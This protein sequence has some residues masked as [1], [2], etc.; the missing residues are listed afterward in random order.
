MASAQAAGLVDDASMRIADLARVPTERRADFCAAL[1][2]L[3]KL[4]REEHEWDVTSA[5]KRE[6]AVRQLTQ[7]EKAATALKACL[8]GLDDAAR[9]KLG[10]YALRHWLFGAAATDEEL[11]FQVMDLVLGGQVKIGLSRVGFFTRI[12]N[13]IRT[14]ASTREW[15]RGTKGGAPSKSFRLPGNPNV[16]AF[17]LFVFHM[18]LLAQSRGGCTTLSIAHRTGT[19]IKILEVAKSYLPN[20]FIP[21]PPP[22]SRMRDLRNHARSIVEKLPRK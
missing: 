17:D 6:A 7:V 16:R 1:P 14:A 2:L 20:G 8:D 9:K 10:I 21:D 15:P 3:F 11:R 18:E 5:P 19:L 4:A 22:L 12:V 13:D